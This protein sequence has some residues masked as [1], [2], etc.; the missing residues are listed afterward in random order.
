MKPIALTHYR[1]FQAHAKGLLFALLLGS[2]TVSTHASG[3]GRGNSGNKPPANKTPTASPRANPSV[4]GAGTGNY[5]VLPAAKPG[6][7]AALGKLPSPPSSAAA[8]AKPYIGTIPRIPAQRQNQIQSP[9]QVKYT[10]LPTTASPAPTTGQAVQSFNVTNAR[11]PQTRIMG[12]AATGRPLTA[13]TIYPRLKAPAGS[14]TPANAAGAQQ[15]E[16][17]QELRDRI[18]DMRA[19]QN[20]QISRPLPQPN[21][22]AALLRQ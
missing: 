2:L 5:G 16:Q 15:P 9:P 19:R 21:N 14:N 18:A 7:S 22:A 6:P 12:A 11:S 13:A 4:S 1:V 10:N 3:P 17:S 8:G 20:A